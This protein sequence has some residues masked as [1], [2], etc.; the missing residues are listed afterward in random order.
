[1]NCGEVPGADFLEV[2]PIKNCAHCSAQVITAKVRNSSDG[3][4]KWR[5]FNAQPIERGGLR[6]YLRHIH[7]R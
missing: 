4:V 6:V 7:P 2:K 3:T 5:N 1:M